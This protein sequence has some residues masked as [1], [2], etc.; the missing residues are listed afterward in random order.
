MLAGV[1][2]FSLSLPSLPPPHFTILKT[3]QELASMALCDK[4]EG[5][6]PKTAQEGN[7]QKSVPR[8]CVQNGFPVGRQV[9]SQGSVAFLGG[10]F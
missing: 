1:F 6:K 7:L 4:G 3:C 2:S 9:F 8:D 5:K 10:A